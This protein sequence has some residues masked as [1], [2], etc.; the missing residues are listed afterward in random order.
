MRIHSRGSGTKLGFL[1]VAM[2]IGLFFVLAS[3]KPALANVTGTIWTN[4]PDS[5]NAG[6]TANM[7]SSLPYA[8]FTAPGVN[9]CAGTNNGTCTS[10]GYTVGDFLNSG[11][12]TITNTFNSFSSSTTMASGTSQNPGP[13]TEVQLTGSIY[14]ITGS[15]LF[16]IAHD[17]GVVISL[18][19]GIGNVLNDPG[20]TSLVT[21]PFTITAPSTGLYTFTLDYAECC[22]APAVLSWTYASSAPVGAPEPS[23][24]LLLALGLLALGAGTLLK[25]HVPDA[26]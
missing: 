18:S 3:A 2:C 21:T 12:A 10:T 25:R 26:A 15:N 19:G 11:D 7:S 16:D 24:I 6:D 5:T 17:D 8:T 1:A 23:S 14:L 22:S 13:G 4:T 9:F 20:P